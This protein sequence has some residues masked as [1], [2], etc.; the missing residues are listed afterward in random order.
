MIISKNGLG[1]SGYESR[2][3]LFSNCF[4]KVNLLPEK[5]WPQD[6]QA[7]VDVAD[8]QMG[9]SDYNQQVLAYNSVIMAMEISA[10]NLENQGFWE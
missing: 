4:V 2:V 5:S 7:F 3:L 10:T 9:G 6:I 8:V 1:S